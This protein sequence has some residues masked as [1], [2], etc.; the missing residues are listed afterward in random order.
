MSPDAT[1]RRSWHLPPLKWIIAGGLGVV[2]IAWL[3]SAISSA[4]GDINLAT[5]DRPYAI[6]FMFVVFDA[7]IPIFPSESLLN[8]GSTLAAQDGSTLQI[9]KLIVAGSAGA[10]VGDSLLY[11][12]SRTVL[13]SFMSARV[14]QAQQNEKVADTFAMLQDQAPV[15]IV[16]GRF[17][18]GVRFVVGATMGLTR[19]PYPR[20]LLWDTIGGIAWASFSCLSSAL[21]ATVLGGQPVL[22]LIL[23]IVITTALLTFLYKRVRRGWE[24]SKGEVA[25][26]G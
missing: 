6:I 16:F 8:A 26:E 24:Q 20:F 17:V 3:V 2:A 10:V 13:R 15:L 25:A 9:W 22:S 4:V 21:V 12:I 19:F 5:I 7:V 23:S 1:D 11:W 14:E 18:P